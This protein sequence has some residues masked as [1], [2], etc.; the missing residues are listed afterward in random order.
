MTE[1]GCYTHC[2]DEKTKSCQ[3]GLNTELT[4]DDD[5]DLSTIVVIVSNE[6]CEE[7]NKSEFKKLSKSNKK[8]NYR[9]KQHSS[10]SRSKERKE[11]KIERSIIAE[12]PHRV[13]DRSNRSESRNRR[14]VSRESHR[15]SSYSRSRS[16]DRRK[17]SSRRRERSRSRHRTRK[18]SSSAEVVRH[19][20]SVV[21]ELMVILTNDTEEPEKEVKETPPPS[22]EVFALEDDILVSVTFNKVNET[23]V[24][25]R[26]TVK[27]A[28]TTQEINDLRG[29][30]PVAV[31]DLDKDRTPS[32]KNVIVLSDSDNG[33]SNE[34]HSSKSGSTASGSIQNRNKSA[35]LPIRCTKP[36][37]KL[38]RKGAKITK[39]SVG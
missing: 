22:K 3:E 33:E 19:A 7:Q 28:N 23:R 21:D 20:P 39:K 35:K 29:V 16:S 36:K 8:R 5:F 24:V 10:R 27:I 17:R 25:T 30:K 37:R 15:R 12:K 11:K 6:E 13:K 32:P 9:A 4:S 34:I 31:I 2:F 1:E 18:R 26:K 38:K 14:S